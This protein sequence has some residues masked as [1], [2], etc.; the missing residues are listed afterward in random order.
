MPERLLF[1]LSL[2]LLAPPAIGLELDGGHEIKADEWEAL[3]QDDRWVHY[4]V[5][6]VEMT[7]DSGIIYCDSAIGIRGE[8]V[9]L[10]GNVIVDD[11]RYLLKAD[12]VHYDL[13]SEIILARGRRVQLWSY[14]D[15]L[16]ALGTHA[17]FRR[18]DRYFYMEERPLMYIGYPD[19]V[20][21]TEVLANRIDYFP[22]T[23][24]AEAIGDVIINTQDITTNSDCA[25][26]Y[27]ETSELILT[28]GPSAMW[29]NSRII[30]QVIEVQ[31][32]EGRIR[33][34]FVSDS[35]KAT[36]GGDEELDDDVDSTAIDRSI[37]LGE[38]IQMDFT[39]GNIDSI[40]TFGQAFSW[41]Y[42]A[43]LD[44]TEF[45]ENS[46]SGDTIV[47][48]LQQD[49]LQSVTVVGNSIGTYVSGKQI[50]QDTSIVYQVDTVDYSARY[51]HYALADSLISLADGASLESGA[52]SLQAQHVLFA[53]DDRTIEAFSA[54][55]ARDSLPDKY[56]F[57]HR[58]QPN[59]IPVILKDG[60][61][62]VYGDYVTYS[63]ETEK[64]RIVQSKSSY[65]EGYY[66]GSQLYRE[67]KNIFYV[68]DG[69]YTT[70]D[71]DEPH[72]HFHSDKMKF[73]QDNKLIARPV[74]LY[75]ER[76]P[77]FVLPYYVFPLKKGRHS[78]I[79]PFSFGKFEQGER[80]V[81]NVGYYW[82]ASEYWDWQGSFDYHEIR[83]TLKFNSTVNFR[84][85][86][87]LDGQL[88]GSYANET[89]Y[90]RASAT[91][92]KPDRWSIEGNY[93]HQL[94]RTFNISAYGQFQS[95]NQFVRD[96]SQNLNERLDRE[97]VSKLTFRKRFSN[98][99]SLSG[100][101]SHTE[102]L[103]TEKR[104]DILPTASLSLPT[105]YPFGSSYTDENGR[106]RTRW[107]Q[108]FTLRYSPS[109]RNFNERITVDSFFVA[110]EDTIINV[111]T[112]G[113][114]DTTI[115]EII[116]TLD[117]RSRK[118]YATITHNPSVTLPRLTLLEYFNFTP[119]VSYSE[120]WT[121]VF[122]TDQSQ[123]RGIEADWYRTYSWRA[124][125][126]FRTDLYGTV[127]P[128]IGPL[129]GLRH[130]ISPTV[131]YSF[132]PDINKHEQLAG[133]A[134]RTGSR[135]SQT[136][137]FGL[138]NVLQSKFLRGGVEQNIELLSVSSSF[139]YD[140]EREFRPLSGLSTSFRS[141]AIPRISLDGSASHTFYDPRKPE[142]N[143]P[144]LLSP[145][146]TN[147]QF[148]ARMSLRGRTSIFDDLAV[149]S[150]REVDTASPFP[151]GGSAA[152]PVAGSGG[153]RGWNASISYSFSESGKHVGFY[154]KTSFVAFTLG[155]WLTPLTEISY[156]QRYDFRRDRTIHNQVRITRKLH[157]WTGS[158]WWVPVGSNA[159]FGFKLYVTGIPEIKLDNNYDSFSSSTIGGF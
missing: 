128:N 127:Y 14:A 22:D 112:L 73:M 27:D 6:N 59:D 18:S 12:S 146:I 100:N 93:N 53:T 87:V 39:D 122:E 49:S 40:V 89:N 71:A 123:A 99:I 113:V 65:Q 116:D 26:L 94:S 58:L 149:T 84:K 80:F 130:V 74:V 95:D 150:P 91:E 25:L 153:N 152:P 133:F 158:L 8:E 15:S 115:N 56:S 86:Y 55:V 33:Q 79:L 51:I 129:I 72:F 69:R 155:F 159:G 48:Q 154:N 137:N 1:I 104:T 10:K 76:L 43:S 156:S 3:R 103:D 54:E 105:I 106:K 109:V 17:R 23:K 4:F 64:G 75:I 77:V 125:M 78:G 141:N 9:R 60:A 42:P 134:P 110:A 30:G 67:Q 157:C 5:G 145:Y 151:A 98:S 139:S 114:A 132:S 148:N 47:F 144:D 120:I 90:D 68:D 140:F 143:E 50:Q 81:Q 19:T 2:L 108:S 24:R 52:A 66:Y 142:T 63:I 7:T 38:H 88:R 136:M 83:R 36:L 119:N 57:A 44:R 61:E 31:F 92:I 13:E 101:L 107:Y 82:A 28:E 70:C 85:R 117:F 121:R 111:D 135:R 138:Q 35:A 147:F 97:L 62:V 34:V 32:D 41:Y 21:M 37:L 16:Y 131:T 124:S 29:G 46:V 118:K 45:T 102:N 96:Y 20:G 126:Q 11:Q